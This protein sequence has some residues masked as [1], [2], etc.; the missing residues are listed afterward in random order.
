M[1]MTI[2]WAGVGQFFITLRTSHS[3]PLGQTSG[4]FVML[5]ITIDREGEVGVK[6]SC[7]KTYF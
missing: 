1:L 2:S 5:I 7:E 4:F 6:L 3:K